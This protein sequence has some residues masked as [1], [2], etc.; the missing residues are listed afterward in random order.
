M[1][2]SDSE[3][4][5]QQA[6]QVVLSGTSR[7]TKVAAIQNVVACDP[8]CVDT[9]FKTRRSFN[10]ILAFVSAHHP[11][12]PDLPLNIRNHIRHLCFNP[13]LCKDTLS[14]EIQQNEDWMRELPDMLQYVL[15]RMHSDQS[16]CISEWTLGE[17]KS[18]V[19]LVDSY[20]KYLQKI[21]Q[22]LS[23]PK[24]D[25]VWDFSHVIG[26]K[27]IGMGHFEVMAYDSQNKHFFTFR[28]GGSNGYDREHA[29]HEAATLT[30]TQYQIT[31]W[32]ELLI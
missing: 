9:F 11:N 25:N 12:R 15:I 32:N 3:T 19:D 29:F 22:T 7:C 14:L 13:F 30:S 24:N 27:Y 10:D 8:K 5:I 4:Q 31:E 17:R 1:Q 18:C 6:L 2:S 23:H 16:I 26:T 28:E 20:R 21:P